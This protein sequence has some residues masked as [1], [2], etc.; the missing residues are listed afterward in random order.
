MILLMCW[1]RDF[2]GNKYLRRGTRI[3]LNV[4][5]CSNVLTERLP[6]LLV[7]KA[8]CPYKV[9]CVEL[10]LFI[11][12]YTV[13]ISRIALVMRNSALFQTRLHA[14]W[15]TLSADKVYKKRP[16]NQVPDCPCRNITRCMSFITCRQVIFRAQHFSDMNCQLYESY[17]SMA[18]KLERPG[19]K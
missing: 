18:S 6:W 15:S 10:F 8:R 16:E 9:K 1:P 19:I 17:L 14:L 13:M 12:C 7:F 2:H 3:R 11:K 4:L 5:N